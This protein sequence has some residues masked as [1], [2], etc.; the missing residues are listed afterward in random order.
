MAGENRHGGKNWNYF[1]KLRNSMEFTG[2]CTFK[3]RVCVLYTL[4]DALTNI[5][6]FLIEVLNELPFYQ[7]QH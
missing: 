2:Q 7:L 6:R 1:L 5:T 4:L 3:A